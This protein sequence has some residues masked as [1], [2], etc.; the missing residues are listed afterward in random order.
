MTMR[1]PLRIFALLALL[2]GTPG[3]ALAGPTDGIDWSAILKA[4]GSAM[5]S[6]RFS[7]FP[8]AAPTVTPVPPATDTPQSTQTPEP[9]APPT[10]TSTNTRTPTR[11]PS[12]TRTQTSTKTPTLTRTPTSTRIPTGTR[13]PTATRTATRTKTIT[14]TPTVTRTPTGT[15]TPTRTKTITPTK[16][17]TPTVDPNSVNGQIDLADAVGDAPSQRLA[18]ALVV[19]PYV[20]SQNSTDT[21]IEIF[22]MSDQQQTLQCFYVRQTD[23]FEVGFLVR[24]TAQQPLSW[25][26]SMGTNNPITSTA[27]P[28]FDGVGELKCAVMPE[29]PDLASHNVL[30]GRALVFGSGETIGYGAIGFQRLTPGAASNVIDL[31]GFTYEACPD[32]L[33]F[34]VFTR[35]VGVT[36]SRL[37]L[38]PCSQDLLTQTP[39]QSTVQLA[40]INEF[41]QVFSSSFRASCLTSLSFSSISTLSSASLGSDTA[42]VV[43]RGVSEPLLGM[44]IDRFEGFG[45]PQATANTPFLDGARSATVIFP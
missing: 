36:P 11:T 5:D 45:Q 37:I 33:H 42:H 2:I 30:Q 40:I 18:S 39:T 23:C 6:W 28:P 35:Q 15:R 12:S 41:E 10:R 9:T 17:A 19:Y 3:V 25:F 24:L 1:K 29:L 20:V 21:R 16:T 4:L 43:V 13:T 14:R 26:A 38:V 32:R 22:N 27:V 44:V 8:A 31:D 7:P 34:Q